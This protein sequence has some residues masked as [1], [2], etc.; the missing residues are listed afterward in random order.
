MDATILLIDGVD[1]DG[2]RDLAAR[3][4]PPISHAPAKRL[5]LVVEYKRP[6]GQERVVKLSKCLNVL[7]ARAAETKDPAAD[8]RGLA[9][10]PVDLVQRRH[11]E[12]RVGSSSPTALDH[13]GRGVASVD[14]EASLT[15]RGE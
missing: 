4:P 7:L 5:F 9:P 2:Q 8:N 15:Q 6:A 12:R 10:R 13:V 1:T 11:P 3:R 14:V